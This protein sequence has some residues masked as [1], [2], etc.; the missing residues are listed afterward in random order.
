MKMEIEETQQRGCP[1]ECIKT[2]KGIWRVLACPSR[3]L[4]IGSFESES[5]GG[6]G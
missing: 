5:R 6:T 1:R 4:G 2:L 3:I